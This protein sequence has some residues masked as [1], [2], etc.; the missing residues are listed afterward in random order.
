MTH[1][2]S[3]SEIEQNITTIYKILN[4]K[5]NISG[6][7]KLFYQTLSYPRQAENPKTPA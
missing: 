5:L 7:E 1:I 2:R 6:V 4:Q 3:G